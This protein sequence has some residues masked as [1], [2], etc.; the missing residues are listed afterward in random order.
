MLR[1]L[2]AL[3]LALPAN[4][5][6]P[7]PADKVGH[8]VGGMAIGAACSITFRW[9][10]GSRAQSSK[11]G[12]AIGLG[13]GLQK[14]WLDD[15]SNKTAIAQG[16]A[17]SHAVERNDAIATALGAAVGSYLVYEISEKWGK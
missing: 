9:S 3:L 11:L 7:P 6:W 5:G 13:M 12:F 15:Y 2:L 17:P 1:P 8:F 10:G 14:E 16:L 4:A